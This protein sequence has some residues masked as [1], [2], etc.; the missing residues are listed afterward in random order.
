MTQDY[1]VCCDVARVTEDLNRQ[2]TEAL[3]VPR[4]L[5]TDGAHTTATQIR[6]SI[7][8]Y[9]Q[10]LKEQ[11]SIGPEFVVNPT[12]QIIGY[13]ITKQGHVYFS[14]KVVYST[15]DNPPVG[16]V[17]EKLFVSA[18]T[19][20]HRP[21]R[22]IRKYLQGFVGT[23]EQWVTLWPVMP[24]EYVHLTLNISKSGEVMYGEN[25]E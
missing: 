19:G 21:R 5:L 10:T 17:T 22:K 1:A 2:L 12:Q 20:P 14:R 15:D 7:S 18:R 9:L 13:R 8:A 3:A 11:R 23:I 25:N 6:E 24:V 16:T 4:E